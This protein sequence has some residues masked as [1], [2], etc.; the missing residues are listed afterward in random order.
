MNASQP[1]YPAERKRKKKKHNWVICLF[2]WVLPF[3]KPI[4]MGLERGVLSV[5][6]CIVR[7]F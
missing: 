2:S 1:L 7:I 3:L 5:R 4:L 6:V